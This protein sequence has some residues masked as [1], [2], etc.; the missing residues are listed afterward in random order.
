M[1]QDRYK[2]AMLR[3]ALQLGKQNNPL[4]LE[5]WDLSRKE[6]REKERDSL[7]IG[8]IQGAE[9]YARFP[10]DENAMESCKNVITYLKAR[11]V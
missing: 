3:I 11:C 10:K 1:F 4:S 8:M 9:L 2:K 5:F 6:I 7:T